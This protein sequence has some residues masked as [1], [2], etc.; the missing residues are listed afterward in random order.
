MLTAVADGASQ[1][2]CVFM[3]L[4][5]NP[6]L[7]DSPAA[8]ALLARKGVGESKVALARGATLNIRVLSP[9]LPD[10]LVELN[11][12]GAGTWREA[13]PGTMSGLAAGAAAA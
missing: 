13:A 8:R 10:L 3:V 6:A 2:G 12:F 1:G 4:P 9:N 5:R 11:D 7:F